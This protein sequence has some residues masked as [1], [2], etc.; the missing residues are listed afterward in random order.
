MPPPLLWRAVTASDGAAEAER[1]RAP[2]G[3]AKEGP[4]ARGGSSAAGRR[5]RRRS[6]YEAPRA[7]ADRGTRLGGAESK[8]RR[9]PRLPAPPSRITLLMQQPGG[10]RRLLVGVGDHQ[11]VGDADPELAPR[12]RLALDHHLAAE[13]PGAPLHE[14]EPHAEAGRAP[15]SRAVAP[16]EELEQL[17]HALGRDAG[18]R[19]AHGEHGRAP[20]LARAHRHRHLALARELEGVGEQVE[21]E[22]A[23]ERLVDA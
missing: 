5:G 15:R 12:A 13:Q 8:R 3:R 16:R 2:G 11:R 18:P 19:V 21:E 9:R 7:A 14:R 23:H 10:G 22:A 4:Y 17:A 20:L 1:R 6:A